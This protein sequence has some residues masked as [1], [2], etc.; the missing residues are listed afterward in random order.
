[1]IE[2]SDL[3]LYYPACRALDHVSFTVPDGQFLALIGK[4]GAGKT[5]VLRA[6]CGIAR[7]EGTVLYDGR[8][9]ENCRSEIAYLSER[10][11][12]PPEMTCEEY[13]TFLAGFFPAFDPARYRSLLD[14]FELP[15]TRPSGGF[16]HGQRS[17]LEAAAAFSKGARYILMDEPFSGRDLFTQKD[18]L[19]LLAAGLRTEETLLLA[20]HDLTQIESFADR[21]LILDGGRIAADASI[22]ALHEAGDTL[23]GFFSKTLH[24]DESRWKEFI[25]D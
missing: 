17:K 6:L 8:R 10:G 13:G 5:S 3:V 20:T 16:S 12:F 7:C 23:T 24:Y 11:S 9:I 22:D 1:M 25:K 2:V 15:R 21:A 14:F 18:F 4:N 19:K